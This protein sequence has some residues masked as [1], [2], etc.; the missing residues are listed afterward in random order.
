M[1]IQHNIMAMSAYRNYTNNVSAMKK[2]LEKLS[3]GYKINRAGDDAAGLAIS[4]KMR[5]QIT[6]LETAQKNAKDG[7]SLVQTAEGAMTEV[8]DMLNRMVELATQSANGTYDNTTDRKQLQKEMDQLRSEINRIADSSNFNGIKLLDGS[9][10]AKG[11]AGRD[12]Q[13]DL[14]DVGT[15]LGVDTVLHRSAADQTTGTEFSVDLHNRQIRN[16]EGDTFEI[17]AGD[18]KIT[19]TGTASAAVAAPVKASAVIAA[20]TGGSAALASAGFE[21]KITV[22]G[23]TAAWEPGSSAGT[24]KFKLGDKGD[25][26]IKAG[27]GGDDRLTFQQAKR[28]TKED[29]VWSPANSVKMT[30]KVGPTAGHAQALDLDDGFSLY[31]EPTGHT[32]VPAS[33]AFSNKA[34]LTAAVAAATTAA[35]SI[36]GG[37]ITT[38]ITVDSVKAQN[39]ATTGAVT[40]AVSGS[41]VVTLKV[42]NAVV[43]TAAQAVATIAASGAVTFDF[44]DYGAITVTAGSAGSITA[45]TVTDALNTKNV[46]GVKVTTAAVSA[47]IAPASGAGNTA[48]GLENIKASLNAASA[49]TGDIV[50]KAASANASTT[51][52]LG[53]GSKTMT[54]TVS[55]SGVVKDTSSNALFTLSGATV[56]AIRTAAAAAGIKVGTFTA[57]SE[58]DNTRPDISNATTGAAVKNAFDAAVASGGYFKTAGASETLTANISGS[59]AT[60]IGAISAATAGVSASIGSI[61]AA[62]LNGKTITVGSVTA[63]LAANAV[64]SSTTG[65]QALKAI[66]DALNAAAAAKARTDLAALGSTGG[67]VTVYYNFR[68]ENGAGSTVVQDA[69]GTLTLKCNTKTY[70]TEDPTDQSSG[71]PGFP[72]W[73]H[74]VSTT[75]I[76]RVGLDGGDRLASTHFTLTQEQVKDGARVQIGEKTYQFSIGSKGNELAS[77][78]V[79]VDISD[80]VDESGKLKGA[81]AMTRAMERLTNAAKDNQTYSVGYDGKRIT[82]TEI[83]QDGDDGVKGKFDLK[84]LDGIAKSLGYTSP[85]VAGNGGLRLQIGDTADSYNQLIVDI[86]DIH[87]NS[88]GIADI[89]IETQDGA[90][91]AVDAIKKAINTV[92][93]IRGTLGATQNR[94]DHTINN[95]SVMTE[96]IQDAESTIRDTDVADEMMAYTKNNILIQSAQAMLAQ[97]NQV[98]QGVLQLLQ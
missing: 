12:S 50:L 66:V 13:F 88:L 70:S 46:A 59:I 55:A 20:I 85:D 77:G 81:D 56:G 75:A 84:T 60:A 79:K 51:W 96:N 36:T 26:T 4:E 76:D 97:A 78:A 73:D 33:A 7:I 15:A 90:A 31:S 67:S 37:S 54:V 89:S 40:V 24:I 19:L 44:G 42:G 5:A 1:R 58:I 80:L 9:M 43:A 98:P 71:D 16:A 29:E 49:A 10:S 39:P 91:A 38:T 63:T 62:Q 82:V 47:T 18:F 68:F 14:P 95:L 53:V 30:F 83:E 23:A 72:N 92:S 61:V 87:T 35:A 3:S 8:H 6:G 32:I 48:S 57:A 93:D 25:I 86:G 41:G 45:S 52:T 27:T 28:P 34:V 11:V 17:D 22:A 94:L 2:N 21:M 69:V 74:N 64:S 65:S